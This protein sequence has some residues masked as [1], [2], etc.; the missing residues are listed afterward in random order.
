MIKSDVKLEFIITVPSIVKSP[1]CGVA[2]STLS[3][4]PTATVTV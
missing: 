4:Q 3:V 2:T 1:I